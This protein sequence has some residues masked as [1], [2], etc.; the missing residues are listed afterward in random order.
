MAAPASA[1]LGPTGTI[2]VTP[3]AA[4]GAGRWLGSVVY[5]GTAGLPAPTI[6]SVD[7]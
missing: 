1:T 7:K 6:V 3:D 5:G 2:T 4:L